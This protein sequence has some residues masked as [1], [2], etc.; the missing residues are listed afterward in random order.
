MALS[1]TYDIQENLTDGKSCAFVDVTPNYGGSNIDYSDV[2]AVRLY[3]GIYINEVSP[4]TLTADA[5]M[6][7]W[8]EYQKT[9]LAPSSYDNITIQL[10]ESYIPFIPNLTV[11]TGDVFVTT[12]RWS[13]YISPATY[14]PTV[15]RNVLTLT[16]AD[17]GITTPLVFPDGVYSLTYEVYTVTDPD[18]I[19]NL[20]ANTQYMV[21][22][23]GTCTYDGNI[24]TTG[25][26]FISANTA[27][28]SFTGGAALVVLNS[29]DFRYF[30]FTFNIEAS[31]VTLILELTRECSCNHDLWYQIQVMR[32]KIE[33]IH[34]SDIQNKTDAQLAQQIILDISIEIET[35]NNLRR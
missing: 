3:F 7:Q 34:F 14:L 21:Y 15:N 12:G 5:L 22:G 11:L 24:Y 18:P 29:I 16:P 4:T 13:Q 8:R 33:S 35:I 25:E 23:N 1:L 32:S 6:D 9:S 26:V 17:L 27:A 30:T 10:G 28:V 2:L 19:V 31:L 20:V